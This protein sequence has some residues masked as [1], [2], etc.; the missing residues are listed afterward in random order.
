ME[1]AGLLKVENKNKKFKSK[2]TDVVESPHFLLR[3]PN[4]NCS[5]THRRSTIGGPDV[6]SYIVPLVG[7]IIIVLPFSILHWA[8]CVIK[9]QSRQSVESSIEAHF[10]TASQLFLLA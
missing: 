4:Q 1:V 6:V 9:A 10:R 8:S 5:F 7:L 3:Y 2:I